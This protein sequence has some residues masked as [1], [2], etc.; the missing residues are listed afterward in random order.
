MVNK[1]TKLPVAQ[2]MAFSILAWSCQVI[3]GT[4]HASNDDN[5]VIQSTYGNGGEI[6]PG[7]IALKHGDKATLFVQPEVGFA[8]KHISGCNGRF[9]NQKYII[10]KAS[11][12]CTVTAEFSAT[13][14]AS[15]L[16]TEQAPSISTTQSSSLNTSTTP[17]VRTPSKMVRFVVLA[18]SVVNY[19]EATAKVDSGNGIVTPMR[20]K[21]RK[22]T[23][24]SFTVAPAQGF[25][26]NEISGCG[27]NTMSSGTIVTPALDKSCTLLVR[28][29]EQQNNLWD[30]FNWD[31][32]NWG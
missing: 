14:T 20:Q 7:A 21:V 1:N 27:I 13:S 15:V 10:D 16:N 28:F 9:E 12:S 29:A 4:A 31:S 11:Y 19:V 22:G 30:S 8:L 18:D 32:A 6:Y 3:T 26:V 5:I 24:A 17:S 23:T 25:I 2:I